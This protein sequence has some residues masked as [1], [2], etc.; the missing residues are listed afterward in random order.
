MLLIID[1]TIS[2]IVFYFIYRYLKNTLFDQSLITP[3]LTMFGT[4]LAFC[5]P[6]PIF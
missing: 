3:F 6:I 1:T 2:I 5:S 4:I